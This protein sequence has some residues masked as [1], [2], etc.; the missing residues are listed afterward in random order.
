MRASASE[1]SATSAAA[2]AVTFTGTD[3]RRG[4]ERP[5]LVI[6]KPSTQRLREERSEDAHAR[7]ESLSLSTFATVLLWVAN[8]WLILLTRSVSKQQAKDTRD[9][10]AESKRSADAMKDVAI[11]T[12]DNA[13]SMQAMFRKQMLAYISVDIGSATY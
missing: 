6:S 7:D 5:P 11:A 4:T 2:S 8:I 10:I 13:T 12:K 3:D 9:A 1:T